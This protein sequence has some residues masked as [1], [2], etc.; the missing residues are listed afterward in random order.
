MHPLGS[1]KGLQIPILFNR[2][3]SILKGTPE[4]QRKDK[5]LSVREILDVSAFY[6]GA[7]KGDKARI[8]RNPSTD[9]FSPYK[10][11]FLS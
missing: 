5:D 11:A 4:I 1:F 9:L 3:A 10:N 8:V 7:T 2:N 6:I